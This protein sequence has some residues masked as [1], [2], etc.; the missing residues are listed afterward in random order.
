MTQ[1]TKDAEALADSVANEILI[2]FY[3]MQ[4]GNSTLDF[5]PLKSR[6][7]EVIT[8]AEQRG[9]E[10]GKADV[11]PSGDARE[12]YA[13]PDIVRQLADHK[14]SLPKAPYTPTQMEEWS[15][16]KVQLLNEFWQ[17]LQFADHIYFIRTGGKQPRPYRTETECERA[18][19]E[20]GIAQ[21]DMLRSALKWI[22]EFSKTSIASEDPSWATNA[23][24][25]VDRVLAAAAAPSPARKRSDEL[26]QDSGPD[27][28]SVHA[29]PLW[30]VSF[31]EKI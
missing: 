4:D 29:N 12:L 27:M 8:A 24:E 26:L 6:I 2:S 28:V 30:D 7:I 23:I 1:T 9:F 22:R 13:M 5:K 17:S 19:F 16:E 20:R 18:G 10:R 21:E 15:L 25:E 3:N 14:L 31:K 11:V